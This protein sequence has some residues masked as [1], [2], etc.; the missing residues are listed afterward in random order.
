MDKDTYENSYDTDENG[1][2]THDKF[3]NAIE[4]FK[5]LASYEFRFLHQPVMGN[6]ALKLILK[7]E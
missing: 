2:V 6:E 4:I 7:L 5:M 1:F 3:F